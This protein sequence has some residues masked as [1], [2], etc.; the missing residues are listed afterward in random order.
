MRKPRLGHDQIVQNRRLGLSP[1]AFF[2][3]NIQVMK[4]HQ[5]TEGPHEHIQEGRLDLV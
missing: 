1:A 2:C 3:Y 4:R 5:R